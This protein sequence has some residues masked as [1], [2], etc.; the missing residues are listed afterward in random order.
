MAV[1][2]W[3]IMMVPIL[4]TVAFM[5]VFQVVFL[6]RNYIDSSIAE[7]QAHLDPLMEEL[8]AD[9][10]A[11]NERLL[12]SLSSTTNGKMLMVSHSGELMAVYSYGHPIDLQE[13]RTDLQVWKR[14]AEGEDYARIL[15]GDY[16][17]REVEADGRVVA[18]ELGVPVRYYGEDAYTILYHSFDELYGV[19]DLNRRQLIILTV[20]LTLSAAV[21]AWLLA[22]GF[23]KPILTIKR[24]VDRLTQGDLSA[25][26]DLH[27]HDELGQ[28]SDS[29][30]ALGQSLQ[31]V[32]VLRKEVIAN[33]S[34]ELRSPLALIG[35]YAEMVRDITWQDDEKR[36]QNLSLIISESKRMSEMVSDILD[37]SQVQSGYLQLKKDR[38]D[39]RDIVE[40]EV[41]HC[42]QSAAENHLALRMHCPDAACTVQV[43]ALKISQVIRNLIYNAINHTADGSAVTVSLTQTASA[44]RVSVVNPGA[45][46]PDEERT[47]IWE[48]YQRSQHQGGRHQ[49]TGIGLSIVSSILDAHGMPYGVDCRDGLIDFWFCYP[50][51]K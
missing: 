26:P 30:E 38:Y 9:D 33:V 13:D 14:I 1:R 10:L 48:R 50:L 34:H 45:P 42:E 46:I 3:C 18:Y 27:M 19:L 32:D 8:R 24:A 35:G 49:G 6:E 5:W 22:R 20:I 21:L 31:R 43:D 39:L 7:A 15:A 47:L 44:Y 2:L 23:A 51:G 40:S 37:Y 16:Y 17:T 41:N 36:N 28:L 25:K 11:E 4:F 12:I 29:V